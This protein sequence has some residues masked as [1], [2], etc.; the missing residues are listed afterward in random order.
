MHIFAFLAS[1]Y[2]AFLYSWVRTG[3]CRSDACPTSAGHLIRY[4]WR[5][6]FRRICQQARWC[7]ICTEAQKGQFFHS[8]LRSKFDHFSLLRSKFDHFLHSSLA[9]PIHN[10]WFARLAAH[11]RVHSASIDRRERDWQRVQY[12]GTIRVSDALFLLPSH[13]IT[14]FYLPPNCAMTSCYHDVQ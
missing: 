11:A 2:V 10:V 6:F 12:F 5:S 3:C 8:L 4:N 14:L 13:S 1:S 9:S 7:Q